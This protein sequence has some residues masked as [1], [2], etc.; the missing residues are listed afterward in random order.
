MLPNSSRTEKP[1]ALPRR[2]MLTEI[3]KALAPQSAEEARSEEEARRHDI[4][5][6]LLERSTEN[7]LNDKKMAPTV[8]RQCKRSTT[9]V[10]LVYTFRAVCAAG[11]I[12]PCFSLRSNFINACLKSND[13]LGEISQ[14]VVKFTDR[15]VRDRNQCWLQK[16][17]K[18][19]NHVHQEG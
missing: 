7:K 4:A 8:M 10:G 5:I 3:P 19:A 11:I 18:S 9:L 6:R 1:D 17:R 2:L 12:D 15:G 14:L 13:T 16:A